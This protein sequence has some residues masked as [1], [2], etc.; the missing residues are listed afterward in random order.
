MSAEL[1]AFADLDRRLVEAARPI[2]IL[3]YL[4]WPTDLRDEFLAGWRAGRPTLPKP[5]YEQL[6]LRDNLEALRAVSAEV[7]PQHPVGRY[8]HQTA[9]S[10]ITAG[11]MLMGVG[12]PA[13]TACSQELYGRPDDR[14][15]SGELTN[16]HAADHFIRATD[17]FKAEGQ[18]IP[19]PEDVTPEQVVEK[20]KEIVAQSFE[21]SKLTIEIDRKLPSKAAAGGR[22]I[23]IQSAP[24]SAVDVEQLIQHEVL[25]HSATMRNGK[26]QPHLKSM[27]LG[28]PR[29]TRTQEGLATLAELMTSTMDL[30][31]LRR[32]ALRIKAIKMALDGADFLEV[33]RYFLE[34]GQDELESYQS[35][36]RVFRGG[37]VRG[38]VAFTKDGVYVQGLLFTHVF[39]RKA[40]QTSKHSYVADLFAGRLTLGDVV[41][42]EPYFE[43][44]WIQRARFLP[45]WVANGACLAASLSYSVFA[46]RISLADFDLEDFLAHDN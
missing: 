21:G 24:F 39:L 32:I 29:T 7:D 13:F 33:F 4:D 10:Y 27:G 28:S 6:D 15:G 14:I 41:A 1:A 19:P 26:E 23:R 3:S 30:G 35:S 5:R 18:F 22:R 12:S 17:E 40:V 36:M 8:I 42:L 44:G 25:V 34:N 16:I 45:P 46:S 38:R 37:D 43:S 2:K 11:A 9:G 20:L 31:R